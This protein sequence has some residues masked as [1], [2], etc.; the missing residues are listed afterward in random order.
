MM[1]KDWA[2][3]NVILFGLCNGLLFSTLRGIR[4]WWRLS[5]LIIDHIYWKNTVKTTW[6]KKTE[7]KSPNPQ[8]T[9]N[10]NPQSSP[11]LPASNPCTQT[12]NLSWPPTTPSTSTAKPTPYSYLWPIP[13][14]KWIRPARSFRTTWRK[15]ASIFQSRRLRLM[16]GILCPGWSSIVGWRVK[17]WERLPGVTWS[18]RPILLRI[19]S[20]STSRKVMRLIKVLLK[21]SSGS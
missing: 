8:N 15:W 16:W 20:V 9:S 2:A 1:R 5:L 12:S 6:P 13:S 3:W 19:W 14:T 18:I 10:K 7:S 4:S 17:I 11:S 21:W